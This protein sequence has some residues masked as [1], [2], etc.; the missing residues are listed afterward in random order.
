MDE[1]K[2]VREQLGKM[3]EH[4]SD[5]E[6]KNTIQCAKVMGMTVP[7]YIVWELKYQ[8]NKTDMYR[9]FWKM[10]YSIIDMTLKIPNP[11]SCGLKNCFNDFMTTLV[12]F[13]DNHKEIK[14]KLLP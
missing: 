11:V 8:L 12:K 4:L 7:E 9:L 5:E 13:M 6:L 1:I 2:K 14:E 3:T 10:G